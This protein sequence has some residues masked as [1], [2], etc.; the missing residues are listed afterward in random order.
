VKWPTVSLSEVAQFDPPAPK[1]GALRPDCAVGFLPMSGLGSECVVA[2][3][4]EERNA[5]EVLSG[6]T[7]FNDGDVLVAKITP[8]FE[9]G[10]AAEI[11]TSAPHVFGSTEF[12]VIRAARAELFPRYLAHYVR[13]PWVRHAGERRMTGSAGQRR[14][15]RNF[16]QELAVPLPPLEEQR[17]IAAILDK[18]DAMRQKR[19]LAL[20][21]LD[22]L[23]QS[24]F[25]DMFGDPIA[26]SRCWPI[27]VLGKMADFENGDRSTNYPSGD[28]LKQSGVLFL[29]GKNIVE[30]RL[31]LET[32]VYISVEKFSSL[33][34]GKAKRGD[35]IITL[36][37]TLGSCCIFDGDA[38]S[39]F[40]NAQ[41]MI[42]RPY[43][44]IDRTF[45][46]TLLTSN[47]SKSLFARMSSG[48][49]VPQLTA[50]Q[51]RDFPIIAPPRDRQSRFS[52]IVSSLQHQRARTVAHSGRTDAFNSTLKHRAFRG[53]L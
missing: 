14:V 42:I 21:K 45:L 23:T 11:R 16:L 44:D 40:I 43:E 6:F 31:D 29:N 35:L 26:N 48:V 15:P 10:K 25:L 1:N 51:L 41:M 50:A 24:I 4:T 20:Q 47:S 22:S 19:R 9:N 5:S 39:A 46:H 34:K 8:C 18:A 7:Y 33:S 38:G 27:T 28:D 3:P 17:R 2:E 12:H 49:A 37:G 52:K 36:R 53:E 32:R 30:D 13:Q